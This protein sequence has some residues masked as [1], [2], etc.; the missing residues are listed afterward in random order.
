MLRVFLYLASTVVT[1][2][3]LERSLLLLVASAS[4]RTIKCVQ[5]NDVFFLFGVP[6]QACCHKQ[7][8]FVTF[9]PVTV[10]AIN[11]RRRLNAITLLHR[12]NVDD[13]ASAVIDSKARYWSKI[14][15]I[16][17]VLAVRGFRDASESSQRLI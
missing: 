14:A 4:H 7:D 10:C 17:L 9:C 2:Q 5:L 12:R 3:Y 13:Y 11:S 1:V 15:I 16:A 8:S 6:V